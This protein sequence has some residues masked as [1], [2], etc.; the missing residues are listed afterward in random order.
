[1]SV[2]RNSP[3]KCCCGGSADDCIIETLPW[4]DDGEGGAVGWTVESGSLLVNGDGTVTI[5]A[6]TRLTRVYEWTDESEEALVVGLPSSL[7]GDVR[8]LFENSGYSGG[9]L[10]GDTGQY[11]LLKPSGM[12]LGARIYWAPENKQYWMGPFTDFYYPLASRLDYPFRKRSVSVD[13]GQA[14]I[15]REFFKYAS[16]AEGYGYDASGD[17]R[18][19]NGGVSCHAWGPHMLI[20]PG[21]P[22]DWSEWQQV[23]D[24]DASPESGVYGL[25]GDRISIETGDTA[26]TLGEMRIT[27]LCYQAPAWGSGFVEAEELGWSVTMDIEL[28]LEGKKVPLTGYAGKVVGSY[29]DDL[30]DGTNDI[31]PPMLGFS[32]EYTQVWAELDGAFYNWDD[33]AG[34]WVIGSTSV[35]TYPVGPEKGLHRIQDAVNISGGNGSHDFDGGLSEHCS[36]HTPTWTGGT[37]STSWDFR[38]FLSWDASRDKTIILVL[39]DEKS[40]A[41]YRWAW[42]GEI[43]GELTEAPQSHSLDP[44]A[45]P[46]HFP[47]DPTPPGGGGTCT[48]SW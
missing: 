11:A 37:S 4:V 31:P 26:V 15:A 12:E 39:F 34:E 8:I 48:V 17:V 27:Q 20:K 2:F 25:V 32:Y 47:S 29:S 7:A 43:D 16:D 5:Y 24:W 45:A 13:A 1:M 42:R 14:V 28:G 9:D 22:S 21:T 35:R 38:V 41:E 46:P 18:S 6:N 40:P 10:V 44:I 23:A 19:R 30:N 33:F 3:G 36:T